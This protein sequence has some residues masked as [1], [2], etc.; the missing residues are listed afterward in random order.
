MLVDRLTEAQL[1]ILKE[2]TDLDF[3]T[4]ADFNTRD[5]HRLTQRKIRI[6]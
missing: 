5:E 1:P 4:E 6:S 2:K 3:E